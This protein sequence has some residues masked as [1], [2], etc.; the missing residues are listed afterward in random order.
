MDQGVPSWWS[1][2]G[3]AGVVKILALVGLLSWLYSAHFYRLFKY[4]LRPDWS[5]GFLIPLFCLYLV[6]N[7]RRELLTGASRGSLWGAVL[8]IVSVAAYVVSI[9]TKFGYPQPLT[10]ITVIAG[11]VLLL[12]G[13]RTLWIALF[14]IGFLVLAIPPPERLYRAITQPLQQGAAAIATAVLNAMP[15]ADVE[16]AGINI[17]YFMKD[18]TYGSFTVAGACSGMRSLMAF[19]ALG[20]AMA[21]FTPRPAWQRVAM[22]IVVVPV[23]LFCNVLRVI[24]TGAFQMH[25]QANLATG[26]PHTILGLLLFGLG[27]LIYMG[28]LWVLDHIYTEEPS[29]A[30]RDRPAGAP[31]T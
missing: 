13:W 7:K 3:S 1:Y 26:T 10:I 18:G 9:Y 4:W 19:I 30:V 8:M 17:A 27:F 23:A 20:L 5:H 25:G 12:R 14:P 29:E 31:P 16:R 21:Y 22:A 24:L 15:G 2:L 6:H 28:V 11:L